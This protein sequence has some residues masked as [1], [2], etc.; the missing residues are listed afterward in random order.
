[1][2]DSPLSGPGAWVAHLASIQ[3]G[4]TRGPGAHPVLR[5]AR[6]PFSGRGWSGLAIGGREVIV[7][8]LTSLKEGPALL[9]HSDPPAF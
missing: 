6:C 9:G 5:L 4:E 2:E 1:M 3:G 7:P 8:V